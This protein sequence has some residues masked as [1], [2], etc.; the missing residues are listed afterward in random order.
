MTWTWLEPDR[1]PAIMGILNVT[2]DSFSDGGKYQRVETAVAQALRMAA[3]G[4]DIIDVGGESTR[5][6]S[7]RQSAR[8]QVER[9]LPV[10]TRLRQALPP[11]V[12]ISIDTSSSEVAAA[13]LEA[14]AAMVNDISAGR[15]AYDM[16]ALVA[17]RG[18]PI[19]LMHMQGQPL[20]MQ[21]NPGYDDVCR[22]VRRFLLERV[23]TA[24]SA[25]VGREQILID[26]GIGFGKRRDDNLDLLNGLGE[27]VALGY[28]VVLGASRKRFLGSLCRETNPKEL[29]GT[30]TAAT[31]LG[32]AAGV[33]VFRVHDVKPNRQ[34]ADL[35]WAL[36]KRL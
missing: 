5:P 33:R 15:D 29:L 2:P 25:G 21:D 8:V 31:A 3:E 14:G 18:V 27:L 23:A 16:L 4:A 17:R 35:A 9:V 20:T 7:A 22:E 34:A 19:V 6:G 13:A 30:T 10:I 36:H 32:A 12:I 24:E 26:P 28:P 1:P 11:S